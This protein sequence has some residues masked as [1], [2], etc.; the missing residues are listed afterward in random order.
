MTPHPARPAKPWTDADEL[1]REDDM[2]R[3]ENERLQARLTLMLEFVAEMCESWGGLYR[4]VQAE[5]DELR[6]AK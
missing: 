6:A 3:A 5:L 2:L 1:Q 4:A